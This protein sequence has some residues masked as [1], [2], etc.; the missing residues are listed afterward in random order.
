VV[1]VDIAQQDAG[2]TVRVCNTG[3]CIPPE[4]LPRLFDRFFPADP[5][6]VAGDAD[7]AGLGLA[8]TRSIAEVHGGRISVTSADDSTCFTLWFPVQSPQAW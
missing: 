5:A 2:S 1:S 7:G 3:N 8:I 6:R 4:Q